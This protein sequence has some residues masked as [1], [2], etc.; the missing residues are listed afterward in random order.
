MLH[1][2]FV[3]ETK[4]HYSENILLHIL[5]PN[6]NIYLLRCGILLTQKIGKIS[7]WIRIRK[8]AIIN[9]NFIGR[10]SNLT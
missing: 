1:E 5:S 4:Y 7:L 6:C 9:E 8:Y 10:S 2:D 3:V